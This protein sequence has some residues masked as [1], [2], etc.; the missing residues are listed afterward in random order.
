MFLARFSYD[1]LPTDRQQ[2]IEHIRREIEAARTSGLKARL[3]I[4][5]T[6][7][8]NCPALQF[9]IELTSLDQLDQFRRGGVGSASET[10]E[11]MRSFSDILRSPPLVEILRAEE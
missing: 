1:V 8:Q 6:R 10:G 5:L 4:P 11:W 2:A 7:G 9:E 3:L